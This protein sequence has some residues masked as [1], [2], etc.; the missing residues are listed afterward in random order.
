MTPIADDRL[1]VFWLDGRASKGHAGG[2]M[3]LRAAEVDGQGR[4]SA[5][6]LVDDRVC[7]CCQTAAATTAAGPVV[8]YRDRSDAEVRDIAVA[9]PGPDARR[10]V[11]ADGWEIAGCPVNGPAVSASD[12][13]LVVA[14]YSAAQDRAAVRVAFASADGPFG[15]PVVVDLG[16]GLPMG[17]V[18]VEWLDEA[19]ALATWLETT[20]AARGEATWMARRISR[21]G[22]VA[23]P[24]R[25]ATTSADN[26]AGFPRFARAGEHL[27]WTWTDADGR[28]HLAQSP[29]ADV[30]GG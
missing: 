12:A 7:D 6:R 25:V 20:D 27:I 14:W 21:D 15:P 3:Q 29:L 24:W 28:V 26:A 10:V 2:Q 16:P 19:H 5:R 9:G 30:S 22:T 1:A 17:R 11:A 13:G 8:V 18:D 23:P 4:V